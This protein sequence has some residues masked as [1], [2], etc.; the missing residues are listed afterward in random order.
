V[1]QSPADEDSLNLTAAYNIS[2]EYEMSVCVAPLAWPGL[3]WPGLTS[4]RLTHSD[5][6]LRKKATY[7]LLM[8]L[9]LLS[10]A[11]VAMCFFERWTVLNA[12]YWACVTITTGPSPPA[13]LSL[14]LSDRLLSV[15]YGDYTP[16]STSG[17]IFTIFY[18]CSESP[19]L[20]LSLPTSR[21]NAFL[22]LAAFSSRSLSKS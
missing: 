21:P 2:F 5:Q 13:D 18:I 10:G 12:F 19:S 7:S 14:S 9:S 22:Q 20:S 11:T 17:R 4:H 3:A 8:I 16:L 6:K 15:G 1:N